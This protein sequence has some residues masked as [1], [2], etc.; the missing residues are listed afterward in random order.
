VGGGGGRG[1]ADVLADVAQQVAHRAQRRTDLGQ[2]G[3]HRRVDLDL[4]QVQLGADVLTE[5]GRALDELRGARGQGSGGAIDDEELLLHP[6]RA[7]GT[8]PGAGL[9]GGRRRGAV[10][11]LRRRLHRRP[12]PCLRAS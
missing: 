9:D 5:R 2:L 11:L 4:A 10:A 12:L 6:D 3:A 7:G 8:R 1:H